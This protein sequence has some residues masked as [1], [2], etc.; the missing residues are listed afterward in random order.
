MVHHMIPFSMQCWLKEKIVKKKEGNLKHF[1]THQY[2]QTN[3]SVASSIQQLQPQQV[4]CEFQFWVLASRLVDGIFD[5][6]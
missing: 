4:Q 3:K 5:E 6:S 2:H 1:E